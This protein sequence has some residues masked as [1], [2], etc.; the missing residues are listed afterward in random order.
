MLHVE[1]P[2]G[3][4]GAVAVGS[5]VPFTQVPPGHHQV[6]RR[7]RVGA[8]AWFQR[9]VRDVVVEPGKVTTVDIDP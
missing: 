1:S 2:G 9:A 3:S 6:M 8:N 5:T 4:D 7:S